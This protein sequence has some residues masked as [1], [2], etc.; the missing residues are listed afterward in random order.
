MAFRFGGV[1][2]LEFVARRCQVL[3]MFIN[4]RL[5]ATVFV[6]QVHVRLLQLE[7]R[8]ARAS[9]TR[10]WA[11][12]LQFLTL[13]GATAGFGSCRQRTKSLSDMTM[14]LA[15][16]LRSSLGRGETSKRFGHSLQEA[17]ASAGW[18]VRA[19]QAILCASR[20]CSFCARPELL[21]L[22]EMFTA[23]DEDHSG[24]LGQYEVRRL[25]KYMGSLAGRAWECNLSLAST[26]LAKA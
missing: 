11:A 18:K 2:E 15:L 23:H 20:F 10:E 19:S 14:L 25:L 22:W 1:S 26:S 12:W 21:S 9:S 3:Q 7:E 4:A 24:F 17:Q 5:H 16:S 8:A 13:L 6:G